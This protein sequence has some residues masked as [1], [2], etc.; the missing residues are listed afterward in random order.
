MSRTKVW[1][2]WVGLGVE[3]M[4]RRAGGEGRVKVRQVGEG[5]E[6]FR[7]NDILTFLGGWVF[8]GYVLLTN[9]PFSTLPAI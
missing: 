2:G 7:L 3:E 6:C 4:R 1:E 9:H 5:R 8:V